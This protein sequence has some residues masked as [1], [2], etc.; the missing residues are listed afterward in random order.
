M[1]VLGAAALFA[2]CADTPERLTSFDPDRL[3]PQR[4]LGLPNKATRDTLVV[5]ETVQLSGNLPTWPNHAPPTATVW[6][7]S[8]PGVATVSGRGLV[9]AVSAGTTVVKAATNQA[10][11]QATILVLAATP[12]TPPPAPTPTPTP[13]PGS[14]VAAPAL[15]QTY[16]NTAPVPVT[17]TTIQ[18]PAGGN[19]QAALNSAQPGDAIVLAAGA[20]F[21]GNFYLPNKS[22]N[23]WITIRS[24]APAS[25]LPAAGRRTTKGYAWAMPKIVTPNAMPALATVAGAHNYRIVDVEFAFAAGVSSAG[26]LVALGTAGSAQTTLAQV[27]RDIVLERVYV[28]G[29]ATVSFQRCIALNSASTAIVDSHLSDCHSN[30]NDSQAI[31]GWNGPGP[32][33][34]VNNYLEGAGEN[35]M[36]GG[37]DPSIPNLVPSDIEIR[38]NHFFKPLSWQGSQ[39]RI[40]NLFELKN[41][42]RVLIDGNIFENNWA[43]AQNGFGLVFKSTNQ[44]GGCGWCTTSDVTFQYNLIRRVGGGISLAGKPEFYPA[45]RAARLRFVHNVFEQVGLSSLAQGGAPGRLFQLEEALAVEYSHNT[46]VGTSNGLLLVGP[47]VANAFV[48]RDNIIG[49]GGVIVSADGKGY[50]T[51]VLNYHVP[52]WQ[53]SGNVLIKGPVGTVNYPAGNVSN[54]SASAL[55]LSVD[56]RPTT[57]PALGLATADGLPPGADRAIVQQKTANVVVP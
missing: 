14:N 43:A 42:R 30:S 49:G 41:S 31:A 51:P 19:F 48:M 37:G 12:T 16:I 52:G 25:N 22:G 32:Y 3:T 50:G 40:K 33:K 34:I 4:S 10:S 2:A 55:G 57:A 44:D 36:F 15:P 13:T 9:T 45:V 24:S 17:G 21:T 18:V 27:P 35:V 26:A 39:W 56:L 5:G 20:T 6:S 23:S 8:N 53:V 28:H 46:G 29:N 38:G 54:T 1:L 11:D 7:S 47:P